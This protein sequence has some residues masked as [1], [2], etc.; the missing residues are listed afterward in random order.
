MDS[1][2]AKAS[3]D[4]YYQSGEAN[5]LLSTGVEIRDTK[6]QRYVHVTVT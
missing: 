4:L 5:S 3:P 2:P 6:A 1:P